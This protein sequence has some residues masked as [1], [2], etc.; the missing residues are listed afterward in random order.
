MHAE[1]LIYSWV[2]KRFLAPDKRE[3]LSLSR[4]V[5]KYKIVYSK[6]TKYVNK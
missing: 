4:L 3:I 2:N 5:K 6:R 1:T